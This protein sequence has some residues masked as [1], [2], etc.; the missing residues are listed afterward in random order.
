[1]SP[2]QPHQREEPSNADLARMIKDSHEETTRRLSETSERLGVLE[3]H[4]VNPTEPEKTLPIRVRDVEGRIRSIDKKHASLSKTAITMIVTFLT[5]LAGL[6]ATW[7][8][9]QAGGSDDQTTRHPSEKR[10]ER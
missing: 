3:H 6:A 7:V 8:W 5:T 9:K 10:T 1:M 4:L 2:V